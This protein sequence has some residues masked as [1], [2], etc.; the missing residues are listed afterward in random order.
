MSIRSD[1]TQKHRKKR[2]SSE[3]NSR[4]ERHDENLGTTRSRATEFSQTPHLQNLKLHT[5]IFILEACRPDLTTGSRD[6]FIF[7]KIFS[8]ISPRILATICPGVCA[9]K[10]CSSSTGTI[11]VSTSHMLCLGAK[12]FP[13]LSPRQGRWNLKCFNVH[14]SIPKFRPQLARTEK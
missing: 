7:V 12:P 8:R 3:Q 5:L 14:V 6:I 9:I 4:M 1:K 10:Y 13:R 11:S 2:R